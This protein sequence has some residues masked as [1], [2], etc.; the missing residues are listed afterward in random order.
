MI[1]KT[2]KNKKIAAT[3]FTL[4]FFFVISQH[5]FTKSRQQQQRTL[6]ILVSKR[7]FCYYYEDS[8]TQ[9]ASNFK[10][11]TERSIM[12]WCELLKRENGEL[13]VSFIMKIQMPD[14]LD[15][16]VKKLTDYIKK[17]KNNSSSPILPMENELIRITEQYFGY[18]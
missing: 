8:L 14:N 15:A 9:D 2:I 6:S 4:I 1:F 5:A 11:G 16:S 10:I 17:Q 7:N 13:N 18:K 12:Y 3:L